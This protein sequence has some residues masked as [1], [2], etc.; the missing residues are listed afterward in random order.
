MR[1]L[2]P[3][4]IRDLSATALHGVGLK[5]L[6]KWKTD[7]LS[8]REDWLL[9]RVCHELAWRMSKRPPSDRCACQ[10]CLEEWMGYWDD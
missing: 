1:R 5:L 6:A 4:W 2:G 7:G 8:P 10:L 3:Y 9:G